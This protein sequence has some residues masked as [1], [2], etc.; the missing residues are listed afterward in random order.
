MKKGILRLILF[1]FGI[2]V[3]GGSSF[4]LLTGPALVAA[5]AVILTLTLVGV[6]WLLFNTDEEED[7]TIYELS[8][9]EEIAAELYEEMRTVKKQELKKK[10]KDAL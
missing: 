6:I 7:L 1:I 3:L 5:A 4:G 10:L 8:V 9:E 2:S